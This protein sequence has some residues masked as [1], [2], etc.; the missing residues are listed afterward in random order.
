MN[1]ERIGKF[2]QEKRKEKGLTQK[3][4]AQKLNITDKAVSKWERGLGCPDVSI[5]EILAKELD[6]S[7]LEILKGRI[8]ENEIIQV[9]EAND[10]IKETIK[11]TRI[12]L[13]ETINKII[14]FII[15]SISLILLLLN[16]ENIISMNKRY[17]Y[18][19]DSEI[20]QTI[21]KNVRTIE[22][23]TEIIL[24]NQ[25]IYEKDD[26]EKIC[27]IL[28]TNITSIKNEKI[29]YETGIKEYTKNEIYIQDMKEVISNISMVE[30]ARILE[31]Y[32]KDKT[33]QQA[34][35]D[36]IYT[37]LLMGIDNNLYSSH[38]YKLENPSIEDSHPMF[39]EDM[40]YM[41]T[42][43]VK[44]SISTYLYLTEQIKKVGEINA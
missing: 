44:T 1:Y 13:K 36:S 12:T 37:K 6:T 17:T 32:N 18:D 2:I 23:N 39:Y 26:Y 4:L 30:L 15:I 14:S 24:N 9:T 8:I 3:E 11:Y 42:I 10:Y 35:T 25:G 31:K 22:A 7:I 16:I 21:K 34:L 43:K 27:E 41:R 38:L 28:N 33:Y 19:F 40:L 29:I 20:N 5:L